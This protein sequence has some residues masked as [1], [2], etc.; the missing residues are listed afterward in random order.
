MLPEVAQDVRIYEVPKFDAAR[1]VCLRQA[2]GR[3][4]HPYCHQSIWEE[5]LVEEEKQIEAHH[6]RRINHPDHMAVFCSLHHGLADR[7]PPV[8]NAEAL[9]TPLT[10]Y[11]PLE[12]DKDLISK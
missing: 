9:I 3:C 8:L 1:I 12:P 4:Q 11:G 5:E 10:E 7:T 6:T 2:N